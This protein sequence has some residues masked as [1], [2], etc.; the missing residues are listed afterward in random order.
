MVRVTWLVLLGRL[1]LLNWQC[2]RPGVGTAVGSWTL[3]CLPS[4]AAFFGNSQ[5][6][7]GPILDR[8]S[9]HTPEIAEIPRQDGQLAGESDRGEAKKNAE[10]VRIKEVDH[11]LSC[12]ESP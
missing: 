2:W 4:L 12:A 9:G 10:M 11:A 3:M 7:H 5:R 6:L 8:E 1:L